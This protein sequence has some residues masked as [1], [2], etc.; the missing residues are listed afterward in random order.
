MRRNSGR[1]NK[2]TSRIV[3]R[4]AVHPDAVEDD[5]IPT[6]FSGWVCQTATALRWPAR[7]LQPEEAVVV[8]ARSK[9]MGPEPEGCPSPVL[10]ITF[11]VEEQFNAVVPEGKPHP[12]SKA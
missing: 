6:C 10:A 12:R 2:F 11:C 1:S 3:V 7:Y 8:R 4:G 5:V 9:T